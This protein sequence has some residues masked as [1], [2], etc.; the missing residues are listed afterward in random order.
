MIPHEDV[1][2]AIAKTK[3]SAAYP[4][5]IA[6]FEFAVLT[7]SRSQEARGAKWEEIN[8]RSATWDIPG[9][10]TKTGK[11]FRVPLNR[12]AVEILEDQKARTGDAPFVFP[13]P[14]G[15]MFPVLGG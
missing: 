9:T 11:A 2:A 6:C 14:R 4:S 15:G 10:R 1:A 8:F 3:A 13:A 7:A 5:T 12:R